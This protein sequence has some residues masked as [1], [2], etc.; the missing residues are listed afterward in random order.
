MISRRFP[1][2]FGRFPKILENLLEGHKNVDEH[3]PKIA[4]DVQGRPED[5]LIIHQ[6]I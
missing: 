2:A 5:I 3:F 4:R 1:T 6:P